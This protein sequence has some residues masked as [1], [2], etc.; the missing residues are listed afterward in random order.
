[1]PAQLSVKHLCHSAAVAT[2]RPSLLAQKQLTT[3]TAG[4]L[5]V[6]IHCWHAYQPQKLPGK[7]FA[8]VGRSAAGGQALQ[9]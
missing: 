2:L 6:G 3:H 7:R 8:I 4:S 9:S 5:A 1:M